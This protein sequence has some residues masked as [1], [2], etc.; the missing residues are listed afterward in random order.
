M[1]RFRPICVLL[2]V[3]LIACGTAKKPANEALETT[4]RSPLAAKADDIPADSWRAALLQAEAVRR[5]S[6][7]VASLVS[8]EEVER[9]RFAVR[10]AGRIGGPEAEAAILAALEDSDPTVRA[11]AAIA[12]SRLDP[13]VWTSR[14][15]FMTRDDSP[16]VRSAVAIALGLL[17]EDGAHEPLAQLI[18]DEDSTVRAT[19]CYAAARLNNA[20]ALVEPILSQVG[21]DDLNVA[22]AATYALSRM[23]GRVQALSFQKRTEVRGRLV[24]LAR[25]PSETMRLL[26]IE[27]LNSPLPG[28]QADTLARLYSQYRDARTRLAVIR[29]TSLAGAPTFVIHERAIRSD[30]PIIVY[31]TLLG[32]ARMKGEGV[33]AILLDSI[34]RDERD[35]IKAAAIEAFPLADSRT[36]LEI[37]N[38]LTMDENPAIIYAAANLLYGQEGEKAAEFAKR[39]F[40]SEFEA[41]RIVGIPA[42]AA[43]AEPL[44]KLL[45]ATVKN[46]KSNEWLAATRAVGYRLD[47]STL[48]NDDRDDALELLADI[49]KRSLREGRPQLLLEIIEVA[50]RHPQQKEAAAI[51]REAAKNESNAVKDAVGAPRKSYRSDDPERYREIVEWAKTPRAAIVTVARPGFLPGRFTI[52]LDTE[53][54][55]VTAWNFAQ[56]AEQGFYNNRPIDHLVPAIRAQFGQGGYG[57]LSDR[58]WRAEPIPHGFAPGTIAAVGDGNGN[59]FGEWM[60]TIEGRPNY[61]GRYYPF[62]R[63]VRN[64]KGV[65]QNIWP[66][67]RL[68]SVE[69]YEGDGSEALPP[70]PQ[71]E[72]VESSE[73]TD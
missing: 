12:S 67:D 48:T 41:I 17:G 68:V 58:E 59:L 13:K 16:A 31:G 21:D 61:L 22:L 73:T 5:W 56:L 18:Q 8:A 4:P 10:A 25:M 28:E 70:L 1:N 3:S 47:R 24:G 43:S 6:D 23:A 44:S 45:G 29:S 50:K 62:G 15:V 26:I 42:M 49:W 52:A 35:W 36:A 38:G 46:G 72:A 64:L 37:A 32:L 71:P 11:E 20:D 55:P 19:A 53:N 51:L 63:V 66:I 33:N 57:S 30:N 39:L 65:V 27:G 40:D 34:I 14:M 69:M 2:L 54:A 9:R 60:V 7:T